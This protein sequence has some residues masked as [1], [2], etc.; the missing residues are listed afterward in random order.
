MWYYVLPL[1]SR[2]SC[3]GYPLQLVGWACVFVYTCMPPLLPL[4]LGLM[5]DL[6]TMV[7]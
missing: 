4:L 1:L 3:E 2:S 5:R 6:V 7:W